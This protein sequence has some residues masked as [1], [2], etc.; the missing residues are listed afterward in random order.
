MAPLWHPDFNDGIVVLLAPLW[1]L[2]AHHRAWSSELLT[3]WKRMVRGECDWAALAMHIWPER[4][5]PKCAEDRSFAIAH[6]LE[7]AL[8]AKDPA[9][10]ESW[11]PRPTSTDELVA[12]RLNSTVQAA[13]THPNP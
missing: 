2:F 8:W 5:I 7:A 13:R 3:Q 10:P 9:D 12:S 1:R 6:G 4:V 11:R